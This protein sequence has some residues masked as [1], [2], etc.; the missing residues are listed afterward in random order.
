MLISGP[1]ERYDP[2]GRP[3]PSIIA[4]ETYWIDEYA[5]FPPDKDEE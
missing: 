3:S 1:K 5:Y 4:E 2:L